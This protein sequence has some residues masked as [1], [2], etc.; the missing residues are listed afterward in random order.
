MTFI[1]EKNDDFKAQY[2]IRKKP[3]IEMKIKWYVAP[4]FYELKFNK[5]VI[6]LS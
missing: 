6:T 1:L 2:N 5:V 4:L 3:V